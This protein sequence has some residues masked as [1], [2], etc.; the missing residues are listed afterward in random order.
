[1][2][3]LPVIVG[4]VKVALRSMRVTDTRLPALPGH[5]VS[6]HF[7][8]IKR[9]RYVLRHMLLASAAL[10]LMT[11]PTGY[12]DAAALLS[13]QLEGS[14]RWRFHMVS[15][16]HGSF[17]AATLKL[18]ENKL[19]AATDPGTGKP[20]A[21]LG[22]RVPSLETEREGLVLVPASLT[23]LTTGTL[24]TA[25]GENGPVYP[26]VNRSAK[27]DFLLTRQTG[28]I[29][30]QAE[31]PPGTF[32][33]LDGLLLAPMP[34]PAAPRTLVPPTDGKLE[35]NNLQADPTITQLAAL[36]E[37]IIDSPTLLP[38]VYA[39]FAPEAVEK[40]WMSESH[41]MMLALDEAFPLRRMGDKVADKLQSKR[42]R[43]CLSQAIYFEARGEPY[44]GQVAVAQVVMNRVLSPHWPNTV[45][46]VVYQNK[47]WRNRCQFSFACDR[48]R[49][50]VRSRGSWTM[51]ETI[52]NKMAEGYVMDGIHTATHYH[53]TYVRPRWAR[54]FN[55]IERIGRHIF[56]RSRTGG[57]S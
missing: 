30:G 25:R 40:G 28:D 50:R 31:A 6:R 18:G 2:K 42:Q 45:C 53:A 23:D 22:F 56:Y 13:G 55:R 46:G 47:H 36:P 44:D 3:S 51:A 34:D 38:V 49:D 5:Y 9:K 43:E 19:R 4:S 32:R 39:A 52:T 20:E 11:I 14:D 17:H 48:I 8:K 24:G 26:R 15:A 33:R 1:M 41:R 29:L 27:G 21:D 37:S 57:W 12:Q 35:D 7:P 54:Y 10:L 16:P